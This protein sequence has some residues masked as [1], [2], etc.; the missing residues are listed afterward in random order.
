[1]GSNWDDDTTDDGT[2]V[3]RHQCHMTSSSSQCPCCLQLHIRLSDVAGAAADWRPWCLAV[4][5]VGLY[6]V[7]ATEIIF[8]WAVAAAAAAVRGVIRSQVSA[9]HCN[10]RNNLSFQR[11]RPSWLQLFDVVISDT[12]SDLITLCNILIAS[13]NYYVYAYFIR[14]LLVKSLPYHSTLTLGYK[15]IACNMA[16]VSLKLMRETEKGIR[17]GRWVEETGRGFKRYKVRFWH[18]PD[19]IDTF[20][21]KRESTNSVL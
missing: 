13:K 1:M 21:S 11:S 2:H 18:Q 10:S 16:V 8:N 5:T 7:L 12:R 9:A 19:F 17:E 3:W 15:K 6:T 20:L 14:F 4:S